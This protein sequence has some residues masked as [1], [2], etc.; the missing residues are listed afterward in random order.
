M[1]ERLLLWVYLIS[2]GSIAALL[3]RRRALDR[4]YLVVVL[5]IAAV[6]VAGL[7]LPAARHLAFLAASV[8]FLVFLVLP[9]LLVRAAR[10][11]VVRGRFGGA[12]TLTRLAAALL[13]SD[14]LR[15]E[16]DVYRAIHGAGGEDHP[17]AAELRQR[18]TSP[19]AY[20]S[21]RARSAP[22]SRCC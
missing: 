12:L 3:A 2:A 17:A 18:L 5:L 6:S 16:R 21:T 8:G 22:P 10:R 14:A 4:W 7:A 13:P 19:S 11:G 15:R 1:E 20:D 9:G